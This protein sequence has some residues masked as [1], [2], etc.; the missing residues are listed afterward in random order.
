MTYK[1]IN[2]QKYYLVITDFHGTVAN[3][4]LNQ[5]FNSRKEAKQAWKDEEIKIPF[6]FQV[7]EKTTYRSKY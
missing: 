7:I 2:K 4:F 5:T 3:A 6:A 1:K